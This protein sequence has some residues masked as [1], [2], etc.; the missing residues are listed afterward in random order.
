MPRSQA[1]HHTKKRKAVYNLQ[2]QSKTLRL[3]LIGPP[4][5]GK[6]TQADRLRTKYGLAH[7]STGD[8]LRDE[9]RRGTPLGLEAQSLISSGQLVADAV[10]LKMMDSRLDQ[11]DASKGFI[12]DGF[13]RSQDQADALVK[14]LEAR[15]SPLSAAVELRLDDEIIV[16]RLTQRRT[17]PTCGRA[18][19]LISNQPRESGKC[20]ADGTTLVHR[21]DD[22]ESVI[23]NRLSVYHQQTAPVV[24]FFQEKGLLVSVDAS[25]SIAEVNQLVDGVLNPA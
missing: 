16:S 23:R 1:R 4:G 7:I 19:H 3:V 17:C 21:E 24:R 5:A 20:D 13:P 18:Y 12:L 8:M 9:V 14:M 6:G 11:P 25:K 22:H 10:I 2:D 15:R